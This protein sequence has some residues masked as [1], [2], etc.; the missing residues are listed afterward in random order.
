MGWDH[1]MSKL[2]IGLIT[3]IV[4]KGLTIGWLLWAPDDFVELDRATV[5]TVF[6]RPADVGAILGPGEVALD[7]EGG[8]RHNRHTQV[9]MDGLLRI[10][11]RGTAAQVREQLGGG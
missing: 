1:A 11:V 5:G 4:A 3:V 10:N 2:T 7:D 6:I 8:T 9:V